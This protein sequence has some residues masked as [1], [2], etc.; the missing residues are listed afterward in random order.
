M[1]IYML[2]ASGVPSTAVRSRSHW[3]GRIYVLKTPTRFSIAGEVCI[4]MD[5]TSMFRLLG[6]PLRS[7]KPPPSFSRGKCSAGDSGI[8]PET[9]RVSQMQLISCPTQPDKVALSAFIPARIRFRTLRALSAAWTTPTMAENL[10]HKLRNVWNKHIPLVVI[11]NLVLSAE[12]L[13]IH[14]C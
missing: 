13:L 11:T 1:H 5:S 2:T 12:Y 3:M 9:C 4:A 10:V 14:A 6:S 8:W 7:W